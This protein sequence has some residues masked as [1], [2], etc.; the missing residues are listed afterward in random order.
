M[1]KEH[2]WGKVIDFVQ[3]GMIWFVI[4][5][6]AISI[7]ALILFDFLAGAGVMLS[8]TQG[9]LMA[10]TSISLATSGLL[11]SILFMAFQSMRSKKKSMGV[12]GLVAFVLAIG[13]SG[14]DVYFD[15]LTAD[16]LRFGYIVSMK[17]LGSNDVHILFRTLI[18]GISL[19]GEGLAIGMIFG[20]PILKGV[21]SDALTT[22][23][24]NPNSGGSIGR[25][26]SYKPQNR[27]NYQTPKNLP[28]PVPT[29]FSGL[30]NGEKNEL[31]H[32]FPK[33]LRG[34]DRGEPTYHPPI[35]TG[36]KINNQRN[37][38]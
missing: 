36:G 19:V 20:M 29:R 26:S 23:N 32:E 1:E 18:G 13:V 21:L 9:N 5:L 28:R 10:S 30:L 37:L 33:G 12:F 17:S 7:L 6:S 25:K 14:L 35:R 22:S 16:Y 38:R 24:Q 3:K 11:M 27:P 8:L 4:L 31:E 34:G 15:S 2:D